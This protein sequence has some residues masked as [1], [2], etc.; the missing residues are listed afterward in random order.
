MPG[1]KVTSYSYPHPPS[2]GARHPPPG[3]HPRKLCLRGARCGAVGI[4]TTDATNYYDSFQSC[5]VGIRPPFAE[6]SG[7]KPP[8]PAGTPPQRGT[9]F[10]DRNAPSSPPLEGWATPGP[11]RCVAWVVKPGVVRE[12][13]ISHLIPCHSREGGNRAWVVLII[14][15]GEYFSVVFF[16]SLVIR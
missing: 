9:L 10:C 15:F 16:Y 14:L 5:A 11:A 12:Y 8:R 6:A 2:R 4:H 1:A 7:D 3:F 13:G